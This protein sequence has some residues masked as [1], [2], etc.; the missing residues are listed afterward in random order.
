MYDE[1]LNMQHVVT[2]NQTFTSGKLCLV[3]M[4]PSWLT[5]RE[6]SHTLT[7]LRNILRQLQQLFFFFFVVEYWTKINAEAP[8]PVYSAALST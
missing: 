4:W 5:K 6:I 2:M 3:Q 7:G 1:R 8:A